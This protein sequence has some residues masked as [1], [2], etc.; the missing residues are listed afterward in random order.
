MLDERLKSILHCRYIFL[1]NTE[2]ALNNY[3]QIKKIKNNF[4][5]MFD[6]LRDI[7]MT[8]NFV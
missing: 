2:K 1:K 6:L 5:I 4:K 7:I 8:C 3:Y